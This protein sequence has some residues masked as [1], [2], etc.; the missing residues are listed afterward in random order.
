MVFFRR[1]AVPFR[2]QV[3]VMVFF[4]RQVVPFGRQVVPFRRQVVSFGRRLSPVVQKEPAVVEKEPNLRPDRTGEG[5]FG[6]LDPARVGE[7]SG[8]FLNYG[9]GVFDP[10]WAVFL[11][12]FPTGGV[13]RKSG[14]C[15]LIQTGACVALVLPFFLSFPSCESFVD[16]NLKNGP[17]KDSLIHKNF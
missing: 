5:R 11:P 9:K 16:R 10:E 2:R 17:K 12:F 4:R 14:K 13:S 3:L 8:G 6:G 1:Q 15:V 7:G